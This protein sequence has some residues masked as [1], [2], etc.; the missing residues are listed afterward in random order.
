MGNLLSFAPRDPSVRLAEDLCRAAA[1]EDGVETVEL[2]S[3]ARKRPARRPTRSPS[4][5]A[6]PTIDSL[7]K[8]VSRD[9]YLARVRKREAGSVAPRPLRRVPLPD[10]AVARIVS[11]AVPL[12]DGHK[13]GVLCK[14]EQKF[15]ISLSRVGR[16]WR[17]AAARRIWCCVDVGDSMKGWPT[18]VQRLLSLADAGKRR[19]IRSHVRNMLIN[20]EKLWDEAPD[21]VKVLPNLRSVTFE[22]AEDGEDWDRDE[23]F[24]TD[25]EED[26]G[27]YDKEELEWLRQDQESRRYEREHGI[28]P[29]GPQSTRCLRG[30]SL[31]RDDNRI[32]TL[33]IAFRTVDADALRDCLRNLPLLRSLE[34]RAFG[35]LSEEAAVQLARGVPSGLKEL[36]IGC[37][38]TGIET[39]LGDRH[40]RSLADRL[41]LSLLAIEG[42]HFLTDAG[43]AHALEKLD[44]LTTL[45]LRDCPQITNLSFARLSTIRL[46]KVALQEMPG[47]TDSA[48]L[49]IARRN[50]GIKTLIVSY[51]ARVNAPIRDLPR[52]LLANLESLDLS[53]LDDLSIELIGTFFRHQRPRLLHLRLTDCPAD[54]ALIESIASSCPNL[55]T[56]RIDGTRAS[57][58]S[59]FVAALKLGKLEVLDVR[60]LPW[61]EGRALET[62]RDGI[63]GPECRVIAGGDKADYD[64]EDSEWIV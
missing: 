50:P 45:R 27:L 5:A 64:D 36:A 46:E 6:Q 58:Q 60:G 61:A 37:G 63:C 2:L 48:I 49:G 1:D 44:G 59:V 35:G 14:Q 8:H 32:R 10:E 51:C 12:C 34:V 25:G 15:A 19:T 21:L 9:D 11:F 28:Y 30:L 41:A 42:A 29:G 22:E 43:L 4:D 31:S 55:L 20:L 33:R 39:M 7:L 53:D 26:L 13:D 52:S 40:L 24:Y 3:Y 62:L 23:E 47:V 38:G 17:W 56:L 57:Q 16:Q 18:A 54:A